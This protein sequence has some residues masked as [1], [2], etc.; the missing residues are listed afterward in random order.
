MPDP[1]PVTSATFC[2]A[3]CVSPWLFRPGAGDLYRAPTACSILKNV[4]R[5]L[6]RRAADRLVT[7][8]DELLVPEILIFQDFSGGLIDFRHRFLSR[9]RRQEQAEP[10]VRLDFRVAQLGESRHFR[11][12]RRAFRAADRER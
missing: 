11:E 5:K 4:F 3:I 7:L 8:V 2:D 1:A 9:P 6:L 10:R 12:Q